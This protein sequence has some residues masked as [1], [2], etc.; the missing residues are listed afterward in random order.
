MKR[1][2]G[3]AIAVA[4]FVGLALCT[5]RTAIGASLWSNFAG[6]MDSRGATILHT[7][8]HIRPAGRRISLPGDFPISIIPSATPD[9]IYVET[10][11]IHDQSISAI[12]ISKGI[13]LSTIQLSKA[14]GG[15]SLSPD[16]STL[17]LSRGLGITE[18]R[19]PYALRLP[20]HEVQRR[21]LSHAVTLYDVNGTHI[22][23]KTGVVLRGLPEDLR[24]TS[25]VLLALDSLY[26]ANL[27]NDTLYR[28][29]GKDF[30]EQVSQRVGYRPFALALSPDKHQLAVAN[31]GAESV[32]LLDPESLAVLKTVGVGKHPCALEYARDGTLFVA[33]SADSTVSV[34][35]G[36]SVIAA[37]RTTQITD[38]RPTGSTPLAMAYD[39]V[40]ARLYVANADN[41]N[42]AVVDTSALPTVR[43]IGFIP[44]AAYPSAVALSDDGRNLF[45]GTA[46]GW[47][48]RTNVPSVDRYPMREPDPA[49]PYDSEGS[50]LS[51]DLAVVDV[52]ADAATT[53]Y[54]L[55][56][57]S[58]T[59]RAN[60][61]RQDN[62]EM[63]GR[64]GLQKIHHAVYIIRE[65]RSYDQILGDLG[66]G[67][68]DPSLA[69]FGEKVTPNAHAIARRW[70]TFDN[71][72]ALGEVSEDGHEWT[73]AGYVTDFIQKAWVNTYSGRAQPDADRRLTRSPEGFLWEH[74]ARY[75]RSYRLYGELDG[76]YGIWNDPHSNAEFGKRL[77]LHSTYRD[78]DAAA[79][80]LKELETFAQRGSFPDLVVIQLPE[81]HTEAFLP[82][83]FTPKA[84]VASN[85][86]ALGEVISGLS[87]SRFW[88][89]T[90]VFVIE[91]DAQDGP[92][93]VDPHRTVSLVASPFARRGRV[94]STHYTTASVLRTIEEILH[95]PP[96]T[97]FDQDATP[98]Y[99]AFT[100]VAEL[101][102]YRVASPRSDLTERNGAAGE[103]ARVSSRL[104]LSHL[105][106][107]PADVMNRLFWNAYGGDR[108][109]R[110]CAR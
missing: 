92:D 108:I 15:M 66:R 47:A 40:R 45:V 21:Q 55:S 51:G 74:A 43:I 100:D 25:G 96:M 82:G 18:R 91:D 32:T 97:Q 28:L 27:E 59:P 81:D 67:N 39:N 78:T 110:C 89:D 85:D 6:M 37:I 9:I 58:T 73:D 94:D 88:R 5:N 7:G 4:V 72:Y 16:A 50:I 90:A 24:S 23:L 31:W 54:D 44:T 69:Y 38:A 79:I 93:H 48:H 11:G 2:V 98:E 65:N 107:V 53:A 42:I 10:A 52:S 49:H 101:A 71:F 109:K 61:P 106:R 8:Y 17:A 105:D 13:V 20:P 83:A 64:A 87:R 95:L 63:R 99:R 22:R 14:Y 36:G 102:E 19:A 104:D 76:Y 75:G 70:V 41:N 26:V 12:D 77:G 1:N 3:A 57:R 33:N 35:R 56:S 86:L 80:F 34:L 62:E 68:G 84:H 46:K 29:S 60:A 30:S 103:N